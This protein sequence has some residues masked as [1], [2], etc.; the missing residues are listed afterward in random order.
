MNTQAVSKIE[1]L[2]VASA[3]LAGGLV[4]APASP[5][6]IVY[7][8]VYKAADMSTVRVLSNILAPIKTAVARENAVGHYLQAPFAKLRGDVIARGLSAVEGL[9]GVLVV[10][11][12]DEAECEIAR[13]LT[14][15]AVLVVGNR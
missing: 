13:V 2:D 8:A 4:T 3:D 1:S 9:T 12:R 10:D 5:L 6:I 11:I 14:E 7:G 15:R